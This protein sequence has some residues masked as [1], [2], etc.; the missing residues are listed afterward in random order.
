VLPDFFIRAHAAVLN[1]RHL[2]NDR[3]RL[4]AWPDVDFLFPD[5]RVAD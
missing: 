1:L 3:R 5:L 2:T 4:T